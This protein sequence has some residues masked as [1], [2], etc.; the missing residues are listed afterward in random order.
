MLLLCGGD[1]EVEPDGEPEAE[2]EPEPDPEDPEPEPEDQVDPNELGNRVEGV[3]D[4]WF[5]SKQT[6][7]DGLSSAG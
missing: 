7:R 3:W 5:R 2:A 4:A 1:P 6:E